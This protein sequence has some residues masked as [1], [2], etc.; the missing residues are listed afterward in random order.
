MKK[1]NL[2]IQ[3]NLKILP[4]MSNTLIHPKFLYRNE[5]YRIPTWGIGGVDRSCY[6]CWWLEVNRNAKMLFALVLK[7]IFAVLRARVIHALE[8]FV[9]T[10]SFVSI[11]YLFFDLQFYDVLSWAWTFWS[12]LAPPMVLNHIL[13]SI[14]F[15]LLEIIK[16]NFVV[17]SSNCFVSLFLII[18][19]LTFVVIG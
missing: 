19:S 17:K 13:I 15:M 11:M 8:R 5:Y 4:F 2:L 18:S 7:Y 16:V 1:I 14:I 9:S 6:R 3:C 12:R 10:Y